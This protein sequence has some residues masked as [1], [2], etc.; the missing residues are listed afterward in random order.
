MRSITPTMS[1]RVG[2][3]D[4]VSESHAKTA[5]TNR[6]RRPLAWS[7]AITVAF[8]VAEAITGWW[9]GSL[10]LLAD[11]G[12]TLTDAGGLA[13]AL[14]AM[15]WA[16]RPA[17]PQKTYGY[18]RVEIL[19]AVVN[20]V[21]LLVVSIFI[22]IEAYRRIFAPQEIATGPML[23]VALLGL[24]VNAVGAV[25]LHGGS[26]ESLNV[27]G[28]YL[29]M[30]GDALGSFGVVVAAVIV[31][32]TGWRWVDPV[33]AA[34]IGLLIVPRTWKLL[35]D[36]VNI[37]LEAT[38][39][40]LD[41]TEIE[42]AMRAVEGVE[43]VH[44]LHIWTLTSGKYAMSAHVAVRAGTDTAEVLRALQ[45]LLHQRFDVHHTTIQVEVLPL[46][47]ISKRE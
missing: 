42:Q 30:L 15:Q 9:T 40:H 24:V 14:W 8:L 22:V 46:V 7:L 38:P 27:R 2:D 25:L 45:A 35:R 36:A 6:R 41:L 28:A 39:P 34:G 13:L 33:V 16:S 44:D 3:S 26:G 17:T 11:A 47:Q 12:H 18:Y 19:A 10:A 29:D 31:R 43:E 4:D 23:V 5:G 21:V 1:P 37:L 20:A 32:F